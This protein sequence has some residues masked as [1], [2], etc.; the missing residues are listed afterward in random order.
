MNDVVIPMN[1]T[2]G[3]IIRHQL[4][5]LRTMLKLALQF[6]LPYSLYR[7][8]ENWQKHRSSVLACR[9]YRAVL[10]RNLQLKD[11]HQAESR[12][13][14]VG[15]GPSLK[16]LDTDLLREEIVFGVNAAYLDPGIQKVRRKYWVVIDY[17]YMET[18]SDVVKALRAIEANVGE[19]TYFFPVQAL[20]ICGKYGLFQ[21]KKVFYFSLSGFADVSNPFTD[22]RLDLTAALPQPHGT[23]ETAIICAAYLGLKHIY[24]IGVDSDWFAFRGTT[25]RHFYTED[26]NPYSIDTRIKDWIDFSQME[27]KLRYGYLLYR[28]YRMLRDAL[29][30]RGVNVYNASGGGLLDV[31]PCVDYNIL[32]NLQ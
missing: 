26:K 14:V 13:F 4:T 17:F 31:F 10:D 6:W 23:T 11:I 7:R 19:A 1:I 20:P 27:S 3:H 2:I 16:K 30:A 15:A 25:S 18:T 9:P 12:C 24:M 32:F 5:I 22:D 29:K 28:N 8:L 21:G